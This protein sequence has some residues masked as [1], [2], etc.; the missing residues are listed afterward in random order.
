MSAPAAHVVLGVEAGAYAYLDVVSSAEERRVLLDLQGRDL[1][2]EIT[3]A[4][5]RLFAAID[6]CEG[7]A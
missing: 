4:L 2:E 3:A 6:D 7:T 5:L 1:V